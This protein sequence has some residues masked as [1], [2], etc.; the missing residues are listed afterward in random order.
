MNVALQSNIYRAQDVMLS[1]PQAETETRPRDAQKEE[2]LQPDHLISPPAT[3]LAD[4]DDPAC[5]AAKTAADGRMRG[6]GKRSAAD[7][8]GGAAKRRLSE[9]LP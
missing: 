5:S 8:G 7:G 2:A 4:S 1:M 3:R 9:T 6:K